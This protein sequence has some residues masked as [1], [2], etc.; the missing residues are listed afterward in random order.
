[1]LRWA[2]PGTRFESRAG[3]LLFGDLLLEI[4]KAVHEPHVGAD[5]SALCLCRVVRI[6][7]AQLGIL[8]DA[9][10]NDQTGRSTCALLAVD[11]HLLPF[12]CSLINGFA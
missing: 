6:V 10:R 3:K 5:P 7:Y 1:M 2:S 8:V 12:L 4:L 11:Q 9:V